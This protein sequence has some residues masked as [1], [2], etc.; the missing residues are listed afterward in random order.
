MVRARSWLLPSAILALTFLVGGETAPRAQAQKKPPMKQEATPAEALETLSGF[1]VELLHTA[2][3]VTEGSFISMAKD[4]KGRLLVAG[5]RSQPITRFALKDGKVDKIDKL[6][7]PISEAMG[8]LYAFDSLYVNGAGPQGFGLYRCRDTKGADQYDDV[9]LLK[10]F[11]GAGEHGP[12]GVVLGPDKKLYVVNGNHTKLP[13]GLAADSPHKN[14]QEDLLLP[15]QWDAGGHAVGILSPGGYVVRTDAD[16]QKW[17]L[18][19][20]GFR[21]AYDIA[22][23]ADGELFTFDS[24]MEWDWGMPWYRPIRVN[25][26][27]SGAEFGW[28]SGTGKWPEYYPDSLPA[29]VNV[30]IGSPTGVLFGTGAKFPAKYQKAFY[31]LDWTYGRILAVHLTPQGAS[32]TGTFENLLAPKSLKGDGPKKPLNLTDLV[33]GDDGAMYFVIGGRNTQSA[34]YRISYVGNESTAA[35]NLHDEAGSK[36]R[37][38]RH[39]LEAFHGKKDAK[40]VET[41]WPHLNSDDRF[42]RYAARIA[43]EAQ[44]VDEWKKRALDEKQPTAALTALLALARCGPR[45]TQADLLTALDK[46]P[47]DK[48]TEAQQLDKLRILGVSFIRQG[49]PASS[50]KKIIAELD[51]QYPNKSERLNR[52]LS[53]LLIHLQAPR[54]AEKS[55]K[56]MANAKTQEDQLHYLFHL[57]TLP[58]GHWTLDQRKEYFSYYKN[59]KPLPH[60]KELLDW[61]ANAGRPYSDGVSFNKFL[62]NFFKEATAN[63]SEAERTE[64]AGLLESINKAAAAT[65]YDVKPRPVVKEWKMADI[66]PLLDKVDKGRNFNKGREAYLVGQ[67]IKCHR[68]GT[69]GGAVGPELTA[70]SNRFSRRDILESIL[71]PSKV[72]SEQYINEVIN[73]KSGKTVVGRVMDDTPE[74]LVIQPNLLSPE[75]VTI[76][77]TDLDSREPSK[78]SPMPEHLVD[79]LTADEIL[80][81]IA[82]LESAGRKDYRSFRP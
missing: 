49:A 59:R 1:K 77:K 16:G 26:C 81:L 17:E 70:V 7:L 53:Q 36:E 75:L 58:I 71:E 73:T 15:R 6:T 27:T 67:C 34:L 62:E 82:Y 32:Y 68:F 56:L 80:D 44:P 72:I 52:E 30:G 12:H 3:P 39:E 78:L 47:L 41:A 9:K 43:V 74:K 22:F 46:F 57:R 35:A 25:H 66:Q 69:E 64:L 65:T 60:P 76:K 20:A 48:L 54:V 8:M 24:D 63:L 51:A 13:D 45:E 79:G 14:Y 5:Q 4:N 50:P 37:K 19:L 40:A 29:T 28:R 33:I 21:N 11:N 38:L 18:M 55:L 42:I 61:F 23:N 10:A 31:I 2:D